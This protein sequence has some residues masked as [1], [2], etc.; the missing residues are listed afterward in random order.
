MWKA[1]ARFT[2][3]GAQVVVCLLG[4]VIVII[5]ILKIKA[6]PCAPGNSGWTFD[7]CIFY[8]VALNLNKT[9]NPICYGENKID[10][11]MN[12][13][14]KSCS[15]DQ[16]F[17]LMECR[18]ILDDILSECGTEKFQTASVPSDKPHKSHCCHTD[19]NCL[20]DTYDPL[21]SYLD[22][23]VSSRHSE[24]SKFC[25]SLAAKVK[26][27][28]DSIYEEAV[29]IFGHLLTKEIKLSGKS[30]RTIQSI[31][32]INQKNLL[33]AQISSASNP[34]QHAALQKLLSATKEKNQ[35]N[36]SS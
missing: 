1:T 18:V 11:V 26:L 29:L 27:L 12:E 22:N 21:W 32:L 2:S 35:G 20:K 5:Y 15:L 30:R 16:S 24:R 23:A 10:F 34:S 4:I 31:K 33:V 6:L 7:L 13:T 3:P 19:E 17:P 9:Q 36:A 8:T 28:E 25:D 14:A